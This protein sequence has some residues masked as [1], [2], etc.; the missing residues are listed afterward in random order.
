MPTWAGSTRCARCEARSRRENPMCSA[1]GQQALVVEAIRPARGLR[2]E[3]SSRRA[4]SRRAARPADSWTS[5]SKPSCSWREPE[6]LSACNQLLLSGSAAPP[7]S[8]PSWAVPRRAHVKGMAA[9][10]VRR[11]TDLATAP[12]ICSTCCAAADATTSCSTPVPGAG[13]ARAG[14]GALG[15]RPRRRD[16][17]AEVWPIWTAPRSARRGGDVGA[18]M[19]RRDWRSRRRLPTW[20]RPSARTPVQVTLRAE[21]PIKGGRAL[22][23]IKKRSASDR[24]RGDAARVGFESD[25]FDGAS[26]SA[27]EGRRGRRDRAGRAVR[28]RRGARHGGWG[29]RARPRRRPPR[30]GRQERHIR[31]DLGG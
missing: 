15:G 18:G 13:R 21:A 7:T 16:R 9:T 24:A 6:H 31:V 1:M 17:R 23:A 19:A 29:E 12:K 25:E 27:S 4:S 20:R 11:V 26:A 5:R 14:G 10:M 2:R 28:G 30:R 3:R 8:R 22:L